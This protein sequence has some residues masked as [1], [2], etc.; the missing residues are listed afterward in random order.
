MSSGKVASWW[1][2]GSRENLPGACLLFG[3]RPSEP[4]PPMPVGTAPRFI[5]LSHMQ[6]GLLSPRMLRLI[7]RFFDPPLPCGW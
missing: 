7:E 2:I 6:R 4:A 1:H 3:D 5:P